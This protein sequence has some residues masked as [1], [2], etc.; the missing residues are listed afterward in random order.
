MPLHLAAT[1]AHH[2]LDLTFHAVEGLAQRQAGNRLRKAFGRGPAEK[3][4]APDPMT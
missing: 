1:L 4:G 2:I 3:A